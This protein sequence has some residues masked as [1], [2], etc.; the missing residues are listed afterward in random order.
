MRESDRSAHPSARVYERHFLRRGDDHDASE[1]ELLA[2]ADVGV[3]RPCG[4]LR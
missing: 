4:V 1:G 3:A 2:H